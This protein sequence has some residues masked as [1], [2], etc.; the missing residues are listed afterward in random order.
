MGPANVLVVG[1]SDLAAGVDCA[2]VLADLGSTCDAEHVVDVAAAYDHLANREQAVELVILCESRRGQYSSSAI[3]ALRTAAPLVRFWRVL[4]SWH[5]GEPRSGRPPA[6]CTSTY[7]HQWHA[8]AGRTLAVGDG[9]AAWQLPLTTSADERTLAES[10][11]PTEQRSGTVIVCA[12]RFESAAALADV[13]RLGGYDSVI[14][15]ERETFRDKDAVAIL[16]DTTPENMGDQPCVEKLRS[17]ACGVPILAVV[18]FPRTDDVR[19]AQ[20]AGVTAVISKPYQ[21]RDL[22][23]QIRRV[24]SGR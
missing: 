22:L 13:C 14:M 12:G 1:E 15:R 3:D 7:W 16:W 23:W 19:R 17:G 5:E 8:R 4:G 24:A 21:V 11:E 2:G 10:A 9:V 18:G 20:P 6:G